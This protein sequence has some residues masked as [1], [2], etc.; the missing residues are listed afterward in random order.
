MLSL[1]SEQFGTESV[2]VTLEWQDILRDIYT[3]VVPEPL[4]KTVRN[5]TIQLE[6]PYNIPHIVKSVATLCGQNTTDDFTLHYG[7]TIL[8]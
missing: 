2:A 1:V 6:V 4:T 8:L 5:S 3:H 7:Q